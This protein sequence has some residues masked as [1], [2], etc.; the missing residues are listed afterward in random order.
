[1]SVDIFI[2]EINKKE[3]INI[4]RIV[5]SFEK[6]LINCFRLYED[7]VGFEDYKMNDFDYIVLYTIWKFIDNFKIEEY[8][9]IMYS[10]YKLEEFYF[11][12][13]MFDSHR[14][15]HILLDTKIVSILDKLIKT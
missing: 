4:R 12:V 8:L 15:I 11:P 3:G 5:N 2:S 13:N 7:H 1:M 6:K 14:C 10:Y 9:I